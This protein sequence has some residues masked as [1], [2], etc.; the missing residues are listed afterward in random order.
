MK[1]S[2]IASIFRSF[3]KDDFI[4]FEKF[5]KSPFFPKRRDVSGFYSLL[6]KYHSE[7]DVSKEM[8]YGELFQGRRYDERKMKN[9]SAQMV[10]LAEEFLIFSALKQDERMK[11]K[12][13]AEEYIKRQ[14]HKMF[15]RSVKTIEEIDSNRK[16]DSGECY[17]YEQNILLMKTENYN[18]KNDYFRAISSKIANTDYTAATFLIKY[19]RSLCD[20]D[21]AIS[22]NIDYETPL[23]KAFRENFDLEKIFNSPEIEASKFGVILKIYYLAYKA[24]ID[25]ENKENYYSFKKI[26][27]ENIHLFS[28][29]E[30]FLL[31][32]D[33]T[34]CCWNNRSAGNH[35][36]GPEQ[37]N[38]YKDMMQ[39]D[40]WRSEASGY[41]QVALYR[42][43]MF[44]ALILKEYEWLSGFITNDSSKLHPE[45]INN[46]ESY[47]W[48][49]YYFET[50]KLESALTHSAKVQYDFFAFKLD[51][52]HILLKIYYELNLFD[53]AYS[54]LD[55]YKHFLRETKEVSDHHK[56]WHEGF[57]IIYTKM[58]KVKS[59]EEYTEAENLNYEFENL[60]HIMSKGWV[61]RE[62]KKLQNQ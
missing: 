3:K 22:Y 43:I 15:E 32:N 18:N 51:I 37:M 46:M 7:F 2:K 56:I 26:F 39:M 49:H 50:G 42:N 60:K 54:L 25:F 20:T 57:I 6:K 13:L 36:F 14:N 52:K 45:F 58:L 34:S 61:V 4:S 16:F 8:F 53:Q 19:L 44:M 47:A 55:T 28:V 38:I 21:A 24:V 10:K 29:S 31:F 41:L 27:Y 1:N 59:M 62:I 11:S 35:E 30:K 33:L 12:L 17:S 48:T 5:M 23:L 9:L 40:A